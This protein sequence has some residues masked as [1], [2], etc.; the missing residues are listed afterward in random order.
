MATYSSQTVAQLKDVLKSRG[1]STAGVKS[2]LIARLEEADKTT[3]SEESKTE[4]NAAEPVGAVSAAPSEEKKETENK[5]EE[6]EEKSEEK[7]VVDAPAATASATEA[8]PVE[9]KKEEEKKVKELTPEERK[10]AALELLNKKLARAKKF[11]SGNVDDLQKQIDRV[12]KFGVEAGTSLAKE[13]GIQDHSLPEKRFHGRGRRLSH[14]GRKG[15]RKG[16]S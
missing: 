15:G 5:S 6:T 13:I 11:D 1:L 16:R 8:A 10:A 3:T 9:E 7:A 4:E 2:E 14:N 12:E